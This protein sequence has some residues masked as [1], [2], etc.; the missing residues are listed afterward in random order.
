[1]V[2]KYYSPDKKICTAEVEYNTYFVPFGFI[3]KHIGNRTIIIK[4]ACHFVISCRKRILNDNNLLG[5]RSVHNSFFC[6]VLKRAKMNY[7]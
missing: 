1:M 3:L 4:N 5:F 6:P 7:K 2:T